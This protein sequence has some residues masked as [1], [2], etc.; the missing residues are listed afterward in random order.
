MRTAQQA[1]REA[2]HRFPVRIRIGI[3]PGG[4]GSRLDQM[5]LW[6]EQ[7][8]GADGWTLTPSGFAFDETARSAG[9]CGIVSD[10]VVSLS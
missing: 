3:P 7:N 5:I 8:C 6:L 2:E 10:A 4:L 1:T 9:T